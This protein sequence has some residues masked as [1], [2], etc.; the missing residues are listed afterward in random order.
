VEARRSEGEHEQVEVEA[1]DVAAPAVD[2]EVVGHT[3]RE[4]MC[5]DVEWRGGAGSRA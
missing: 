1:K 2:S 5:G 4:D 3:T